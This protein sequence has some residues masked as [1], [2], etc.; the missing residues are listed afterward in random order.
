[1]GSDSSFF[2]QIGDFEILLVH[3]VIFFFTKP[4]FP[5]GFALFGMGSGN[6]LRSFPASSCLYT[7][8]TDVPPLPGTISPVPSDPFFFFFSNQRADNQHVFSSSLAK[9]FAMLDCL[10]PRDISYFPLPLLSIALWPFPSPGTWVLPSRCSLDKLSA[11][12]RAGYLFSFQQSFWLVASILL[13]PRFCRRLPRILSE[14]EPAGV[15]CGPPPT[16]SSA[17]DRRL[18]FFF[19]IGRWPYKLYR[20][21]RF[22]FFPL[23]RFPL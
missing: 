12:S 7:H 23:V 18:R 17:V 16:L 20:C 19:H 15:I 9:E 10:H 21:Q 1:M 13:F 22:K 14:F 6:F 11:P 5:S 3:Q 4:L 8:S 2:S